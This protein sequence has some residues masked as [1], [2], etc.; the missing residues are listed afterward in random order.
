MKL[1]QMYCTHF[2]RV[3]MSE[4]SSFLGVGLPLDSRPLL[5]LLSCNKHRC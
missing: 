4:F 3:P 5:P 2:S 1:E